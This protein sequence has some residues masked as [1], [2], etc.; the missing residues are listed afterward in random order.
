[1]VQTGQRML[2]N[3]QRCIKI[4]YY[5]ELLN[6]DITKYYMAAAEE[7][8]FEVSIT[9]VRKWITSIYSQCYKCS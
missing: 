6:G 1:M 5:H 8:N 7:D 4:G 9:E 3:N 2:V